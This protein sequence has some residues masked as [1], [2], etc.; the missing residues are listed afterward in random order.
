[1]ND[2]ADIAFWIVLWTSSFA[3]GVVLLLVL[4][5]PTWKR[6]LFA[7][8]TCAL[9]ALL[10]AAP[11]LSPVKGNTLLLLGA[12]AAVGLVLTLALNGLMTLIAKLGGQ[13]LID[14]VRR[15]I[16]PSLWSETAEFKPYAAAQRWLVATAAACGAVTL[17]LIAHGEFW[18]ALLE[19]L[20]PIGIIASVFL[21][22]ASFVLVG[23]IQE[24]VLQSA[25]ADVKGG[26][27]DLRLADLE[28]LARK[29]TTWGVVRF[30]IVVL[31]VFVLQILFDSVDQS[32]RNADV[33][34]MFSILRGLTPGIWGY[35]WCAALQAYPSGKRLA[36]STLKGSTMCAAVLFWAFMSD[37]VT[38]IIYVDLLHSSQQT[39]DWLSLALAI[40]PA[41]F[42]GLLFAWLLGFYLVGF[43]AWCGA[44]VICK[45]SGP[46]FW[47]VLF[48]VL[49][50][51][52]LI[53]D[54]PYWLQSGSADT[55]RPHI[56]I[57][58]L[59]GTFGILI[60]L[61]ASGFPQLILL[62]RSSKAQS[63]VPAST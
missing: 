8:T 17:T 49:I 48:V 28:N 52:G 27:T 10:I 46:A 53:N 47:I 39:A 3:F 20:T 24:F 58:T 11:S 43:Q 2:D 35:Y 5:V 36:V 34:T 4:F 30:G 29:L 55:L 56:L 16:N 19:S 22:G 61:F 33:S 6:Y 25:L 44:L 54:I 1:M 41:P 9:A 37:G 23:P 13:R 63:D 62:A 38:S 32:I 42:L 31:F 18:R 60:G 12:G 59:L 15:Q 50:V 7:M 51:S 14:F 57:P 45:V 21:A 26:T 40:P